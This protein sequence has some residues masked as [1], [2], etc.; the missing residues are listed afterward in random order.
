MV[1]YKKKEVKLQNGGFRNY[2]SKLYKNGNEK[3]ITK[4]EYLKKMS[5]AGGNNLGYSRTRVANFLYDQLSSKI[6]AL[7]NSPDNSY[8]N[9]LYNWFDEKKEEI[10][11]ILDLFDNNGKL[12]EGNLS[13]TLFNDYYK[14]SMLHV[15]RYLENCNKFEGKPIH[16]TFGVNI[17]TDDLRTK[18]SSN[19]EL[20]N[21]V[22]EALRAL[23][24]RKFN[25]DLFESI[26]KLKKLNIDTTTIDS[27]CGPEGNPRSL[28]DKVIEEKCIPDKDNE[29][30]VVISFFKDYDSKL[31]DNRIYIEATGPWH[32]VTW[33][34]TTMMQTVYEV[35]LKDK[36]DREKKDYVTWL[37]ES[38][39]RC[40]R[41]VHSIK[42]LEVTR[43]EFPMKGALFTG[44][45]TGGYAFI[46]LQNLFVKDNYE[47]CIGTSSVD[48]WYTLREITGRKNEDL[49]QPVGT[50]AH[51]LSMV[52]S[53]L[54]PD[55]DNNSG[56]PLTQLIGH[57]L[58]YLKSSP[59][60]FIENKS[61]MPM[62]PDTLGTE[63][64]VR[65]A[66]LIKVPLNHKPEYNFSKNNRKNGELIRF[67]DII[68]SARQDSGKLED[69]V[70]IMDKYCFDGSIM[71]SEIDN[72]ETL[73]EASKL[74]RKNG[75]HYAFQTFGAGGFF[76]DSEAAWNKN[77]KN[78]SMAVKAVRVYVNYEETSV[79]PIKL[80]DV[81]GKLEINGLLSNINSNIQRKRSNNFKNYSKRNNMNTSNIITKIQ[82]I[83][84][85][86]LLSIGV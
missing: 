48:S 30:K 43:G 31:K 74:R 62:L 84:D 33:L 61:M 14:W 29:D 76:G 57:Y 28:I 64:F 19:K 77:I 66:S 21:K 83:F 60:G 85:E 73:E 18:L 9:I 42:E 5:G 6:K 50:H 69:F 23:K 7:N 4:Q 59:Q 15:I 63:A 75:G 55:I 45:R 65:V 53:T 54:L 8:D 39:R 86:E 10:K 20:Q 26:I 41:S 12:I 35:L 68:G 11:K 49:L 1:E 22:L 2:Y 71:A 36:L 70:K 16:V 56:Y 3:R 25:R 82:R 37:F 58:Y 67:L 46:L 47:N 44:R 78:I 51:E 17:R 79:K 27:I 81:D 24:N 34:E 13:A 40:S 72:S 80:G 38:L 32:R 52:I